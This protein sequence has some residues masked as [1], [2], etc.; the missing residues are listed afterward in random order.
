MSGKKVFISYSHDSEEH[1]ERVLQLSERLRQDS[2]E[3][4]L[5]QYENGSPIQGWPR[6]MLDMLDVSDFVLVV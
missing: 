4:I 2:V 6:W 1:R 5:D 3:T